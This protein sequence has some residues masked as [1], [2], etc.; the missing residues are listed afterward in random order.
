MRNFRRLIVSAIVAMVAISCQQIGESNLLVGSKV[1]FTADTEGTS[2]TTMGEN[3]SVVWSDGDQIQMFGIK[4]DLSLSNLQ[5][6]ELVGGAGTTHGVFE[7]ELDRAYDSYYALYPVSMFDGEYASGQFTMQLSS[8][9]IFTE[10]NFV[11]GANP[12]IA[13][14]TKDSGLQFRNVCG[15]LELK[16]RGVGE[17]DRIVIS[18]VS[19]APKPLSANFVVDATTLEIVGHTDGL[20]SMLARLENPIE[21]SET[22]S[23]SIY[24]V[25]PPG[26]YKKLSVTTFDTS[27]NSTIRTATNPVT[28]TRSEITPVTEFE[29]KVEI[30]PYVSINYLEDKSNF[31]TSRV[32]A[33]MNDATAGL[34]VAVLHDDE[35][36]DYEATDAQ[37]AQQ[38]GTRFEKDSST[39][40]MEFT[41]QTYSLMGQTIHMLALPYDSDGNFGEVAKISF[42]T[43]VVPINTDY[44]VSVS[45]E[46][47]I[48]ANS[49]DINFATTPADAMLRASI[50]TSSAYNGLELWVPNINTA[51]EAAEVT[52]TAVNGVVN[53]KLGNLLPQTEYTLVYRVMNGVGDGVYSDT[54]TAYSEYKVYTFTT[55]AESGSDDEELEDP[56]TN[57]ETG[58]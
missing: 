3:Y 30:A 12:M 15:I 2:R 6:Y 5:Q 9:R 31:Y 32:L 42:V 56:D 35:Y 23:R 29:H 16:I 7:G 21:L 19:D 20:T 52:T 58:W 4:A 38:M 18:D 55:L 43:N 46:P 40:L 24:V 48:T 28:I 37:V 10:R 25:L 36:G 11:D 33:Y 22:E 14:G 47:T 27:G 17:V 49:I 34:Y 51:T 13:S 1:R 44:M 50:W 8:D 41:L 26:E 53:I 39:S 54:F 45:G 57:P